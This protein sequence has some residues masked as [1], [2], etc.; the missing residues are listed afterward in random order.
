MT[1]GHLLVACALLAFECLDTTALLALRS[2]RITTCIAASIA[3]LKWS[4][5]K[6]D[7]Y[8]FWSFRI[9]LFDERSDC[10]TYPKSLAW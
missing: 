2:D 4:V 10:L 7:E 8:I 6:H 5:C 1:L 3:S 9:K